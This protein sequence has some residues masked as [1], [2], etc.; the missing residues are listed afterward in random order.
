MQSF[1]SSAG[2]FFSFMQQQQQGHHLVGHYLCDGYPGM[3]LAIIIRFDTAAGQYGL[4]LEWSCLGLDPY[5]DTLQEWYQYRF[6]DPA[7]LLNFLENH[8]GIAVTAIPVKYRFDP[9]SF[10]DPVKNADQQHVFE[11]A[12]QRFREDFKKGKF[13]IDGIEPVN[14][15]A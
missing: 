4:H 7:S 13:G 8:Y 2:S 6:Q 14:Q 3:V 15:S 1:F 11:A 12:W 5:G 9:A 10:P